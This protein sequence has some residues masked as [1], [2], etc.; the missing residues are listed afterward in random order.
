MCGVSAQELVLLQLTKTSKDFYLLL[1]PFRYSGST[2]ERGRGGV[3]IK[4][5]LSVNSTGVASWRD[6]SLSTLQ[7]ASLFCVVTLGLS[8]ASW[9][10]LPSQALSPLE[11]TNQWA[12]LCPNHPWSLFS[13][14]T[15]KAGV[16][17]PA[18]S[19]SVIFEWIVPK[20]RAQPVETLKDVSTCPLCT[21]ICSAGPGSLTFP[22][23]L[24][25]VNT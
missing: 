5:P 9:L 13:P 10:P 14:G 22:L 25:P 8:F 21:S 24:V 19:V 16:E 4:K 23:E 6:A 11:L 2:A 7:L 15:G 20:P 18:G 3:L 12:P 17:Q 1:W